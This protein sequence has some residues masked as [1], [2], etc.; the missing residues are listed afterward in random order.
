MRSPEFSIISIYGSVKVPAMLPEIVLYI[1]FLC[2]YCW[3]CLRLSR[4]SG[5]NIAYLS[6]NNFIKAVDGMM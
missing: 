3:Y 6:Q 1:G 2:L 4:Y 5:L